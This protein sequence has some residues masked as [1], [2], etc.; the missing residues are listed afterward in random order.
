[1]QHPYAYRMTAA[2]TLILLL[3]STP[4]FAGSDGRVELAVAPRAEDHTKPPASVDGKHLTA[5]E[6]QEFM[7]PRMGQLGG[8]PQPSVQQAA[9]NRAIRTRLFAAE[10]TRR[11]IRAPPGSDAFA[12]A[13]LSQALIQAELGRLGI[14]VDAVDDAQAVAD[15]NARAYFEAHPEKMLRLGAVAVR[16]IVLADEASAAALLRDHADSSAEQF[17]RLAS[18]RSMDADS[19]K[20]GGL[21]GFFDHVSVGD[22]SDRFGRDVAS[23]VFA[24][25]RAGDVGFA[26]ADGGQ[27]VVVRAE[28][29]QFKKMAWNAE[30]A[31]RARSHIVLERRQR[32]LDDLDRRL[33][34]AARI[35]VDESALSRVPCLTTAGSARS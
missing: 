29:V 23:L 22:L 34:A 7:Q 32:A 19:A 26:R 11:G 25:R 30:L 24:L 6:I 17:G 12:R 9:L 10:A 16:V 18:Q 3:Y 33:R 28:E 27:F 5:V 4:T 15:S 2:L 13:Y 14:H 21:I 1:M 8:Q 20:Q 31:R 35:H